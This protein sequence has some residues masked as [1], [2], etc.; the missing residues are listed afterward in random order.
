[1]GPH[2]VNPPLSSQHSDEDCQRLD[3]N[4]PSSMFND[5]NPT[6][7]YSSQQ[8]EQKYRPPHLNRMNSGKQ[9]I[10][11]DLIPELEVLILLV[12]NV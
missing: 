1:M 5:Y 2:S 12:F 11:R 7:F 10:C 9:M 3:T 6:E 8:V 4:P